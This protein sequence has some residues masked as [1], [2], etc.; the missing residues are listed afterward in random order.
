M[1]SRYHMSS[2]L[3]VAF[4]LVATLSFPAL[5]DAQIDRSHA[6]LP[7]PAPAVRVADAKHSSLPNG[8]HLIVVE[9]HKLP[10]VSVQ[11]RFDHPP[12]MQGDKAG[13]QDLI[14][15]LLTSGTVRRSKEQIDETVDRLGAQLSGAQDGL[16]ASS[17]K[18]NFKELM[19][20]VYEV[21]TAPSFL[22]AEFEKAK[23][24]AMSGLK[25][26]ADDPDQIASEVGRAITYG[27]GFPY[28]EVATE[29]SLGKVTRAQVYAYYQRFFRPESCYMVFV[30][31]ITET[32]A[33]QMAN[34]L[35]GDWKGAEIK[36]TTDENKVETV[37]DLGK[38]MMP[39][40]VPQM[41]GPRQVCFVDRPGSAQ[42]VLKCVFPVELRPNDPMAL[43]AQVMNT[44]LGGGVFNARLMQNLREARGFTYGAYSSLDADRWCGAFSAGCS[45]RNDVTDSAVTELMYE[46]ERM[47]D[48]PVTADE[49]ALAKSY[50]AGS[51]AR[52]LEDPRTVARFALNTLLFNLPSDFYSTYLKRLDTVSVESVQ[53]AAKRFLK[54]DNAQIL[55]VGD[56]EQVANKL[57]PLS[58]TRAVVYLDVN[59]DTFRET[60]EMPPP[61]MKA[62]DVLDAYIKAIGGISAIT[63]L[64]S[65]RK[66]YT[67]DL[68][69]REVTMT[70]LNAKPLKYA[71][72]TSM[73]PMVMQKL[74]FDGV[75]GYRTGLEGKKELIDEE[76]EEA[77]QSAYM[78]PELF[79]RELDYKTLLSGVVE[80]NGRKCYR[81]SVQKASGA[82]FMEYYDQETDLKVR[83]VE[84][85]PTEEGTFQ[86]TTDY[87]DYEAVEGVKFPRTIEQ[88]AGMNFLFKAKLIEANKPID[89][90]S[91]STE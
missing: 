36:R 8:I 3:R 14:G 63:K 62:E 25:S 53:L 71:T 41:N 66:E 89:P 16:F 50:M 43:S 39:T 76:L 68:Q 86:V 38:I 85:Q 35:F 46:I 17:L 23:T 12:V 26:R 18:K 47:R 20:L 70:E 73:G 22:P 80:I 67:A 10:V 7:G 37:K 29:A 44:I 9:N 72:T 75:R 83:R 49:L 24:R 55:V 88:N 34:D 1:N 40:F 4:A 27:K 77:R 51:F 54:P 57:A 81:I 6:P 30:G 87:S 32:E 64:T 78:V 74:V 60:F 2:S 15:E 61:N 52:S 33:K 11:L 59:G 82:S 90:A 69:G 19:R 65:L 42:S 28:G 48:E 13:Y 91:F 31:D 58:F 79:Y 45:V 84:T 21:T 56:K 5:M